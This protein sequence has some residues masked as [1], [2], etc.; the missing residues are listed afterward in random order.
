MTVLLAAF[1]LAQLPYVTEECAAS[2]ACQDKV[3]QLWYWGQVLSTEDLTAE[4]CA[5]ELERLRPQI[6]PFGGLE[7]RL[8][9]VE[10]EGA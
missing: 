4:E 2:F 9:I 8:V 7:C 10:R 1:L 3:Y 5:A 6:T